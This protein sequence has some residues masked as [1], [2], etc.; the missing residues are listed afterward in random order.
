MK[1]SILLTACVILVS[2][3]GS[4]INPTYSVRIDNPEKALLSC[5]RTVDGETK[6]EDLSEATMTYTSNR[7]N[8]FIYIW[9]SKKEKG[10]QKI[11]TALVRNDKDQETDECAT[12]FC[13]VSSSGITK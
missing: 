6:T 8:E 3:C 9:C 1:R 10:T 12:D 13:V 11:K 4:E 2:A 7:A 5:T